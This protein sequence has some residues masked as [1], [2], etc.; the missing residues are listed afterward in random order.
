MPH[1]EDEN[2]IDGNDNEQQQQP[3]D[4]DIFIGK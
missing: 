1:L 2:G 3:N 4:N